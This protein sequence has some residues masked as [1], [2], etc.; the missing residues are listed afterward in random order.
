MQIPG[1]T[2]YKMNPPKF[3][4]NVSANGTEEISQTIKLSKEPFKSFA[5]D[6]KRVSYSH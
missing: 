1:M 3:T 6:V 4:R 5:P 2:C